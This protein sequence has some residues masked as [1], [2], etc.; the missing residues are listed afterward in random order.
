M[1]WFR[2]SLQINTKTIKLDSPTCREKRHYFGPYITYSDL[3]PLAT[4]IGDD[5]EKIISY[6]LVLRQASLDHF[7][8]ELLVTFPCILGEVIEKGEDSQLVQAKPLHAGVSQMV[9]AKHTGYHETIGGI[10]LKLQRETKRKEGNDVAAKICHSFGD[11]N[12]SGAFG[13]Q[14]EKLDELIDLFCHR[15]LENT[16]RALIDRRAHDPALS[17]MGLLVNYCE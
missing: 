6:I 9:R 11:I 4:C 2:I 16:H 14:E 15:R 17:P 3:L 1:W 13:W 10:C 5:G 12:R 7:L 8:Y